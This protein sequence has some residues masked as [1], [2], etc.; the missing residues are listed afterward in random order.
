MTATDSKANAL[1]ELIKHLPDLTNKYDMKVGMLVFVKTKSCLSKFFGGNA[2]WSP[3]F[4]GT[5]GTVPVVTTGT[6]TF[7][8]VTTAPFYPETITTGGTTIYQTGKIIGNSSITINPTDI[9]WTSE[10]YDEAVCTTSNISHT[11]TQK[12]RGWFDTYDCSSIGSSNKLGMSTLSGFGRKRKLGRNRV[13]NKQKIITSSTLASNTFT[14]STFTI[15]TGAT[16]TIKALKPDEFYVAGYKTIQD[17]FQRNSTD[18]TQNDKWSDKEEKKFKNERLPVFGKPFN[19]II[20]DRFIPAFE[21]ERGE[22]IET[23]SLI[24]RMYKVLFGEKNC[25]WFTE[26]VLMPMKPKTCPLKSEYK[27]ENNK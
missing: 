14:N 19:G 20:V 21:T 18:V 10:Q 9:T 2:N 15:K 5:A 6:V 22:K 4:T 8:T 7:P 13:T 11:E 17:Y 27:K 12:L 25:L 23:S 24:P 16:T 3:N 26:D 1:Q